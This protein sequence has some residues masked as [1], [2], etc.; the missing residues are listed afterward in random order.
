VHDVAI[1]LLAFGTDVVLELLDPAFAFFPGLKVSAGTSN[2]VKGGHLLRRIKHISQQN[3]AARLADIDWERLTLLLWDD[4]AFLGHGSGIIGPSKLSHQCISAVVVEVHASD[5][6]IIQSTGPASTL[7]VITTACTIESAS[8]AASVRTPPTGTGKGRALVA[9]LVLTLKA[10][11]KI[12][13]RFR[14]EFIV[15]ETDSDGTSCEV[16]TVH[17]LKSLTSLIGITEPI[18]ALVLHWHHKG[19]D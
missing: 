8:G 6:G 10:L 14:R 2:G 9:W 4:S 5:I 17:F 13:C 15:A 19:F 18:I 12:G 16:K 7:V 1:F 11:K 3:A